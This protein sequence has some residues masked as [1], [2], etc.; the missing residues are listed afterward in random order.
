MVSSKKALPSWNN[1]RGIAIWIDREFLEHE[2]VYLEDVIREVKS[3]F[4]ED[5]LDFDDVGELSLSKSLRKE[6]QIMFES[7]RIW[8]RGERAWR[9]LDDDEIAQRMRVWK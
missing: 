6:I 7:T 3:E 9:R 5:H 1:P 8:Q 4:G 2:I